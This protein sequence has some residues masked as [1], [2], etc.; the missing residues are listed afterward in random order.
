MD[1]QTRQNWL[2]VKTA[3]EAAGK[4]ESHFYKRAVAVSKGQEDPGFEKYT[5]QL[6]Q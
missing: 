3:L 2:K 5:A 4:T 1:D 6:F